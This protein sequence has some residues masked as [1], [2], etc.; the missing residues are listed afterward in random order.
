MEDFG[1]KVGGLWEKVEIQIKNLDRINPQS[2]PSNQP[3]VAG[4]RPILFRWIAQRFHR[5]LLRTRGCVED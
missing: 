5:R 3:Y 4:K 1:E 2:T